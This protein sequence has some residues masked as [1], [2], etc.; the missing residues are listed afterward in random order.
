MRFTARPRMWGGVAPYGDAFHGPPPGR[1]ASRRRAMAFAPTLSLN[2]TQRTGLQRP[3]THIQYDMGREGGVHFALGLDGC[4]RH[5][6][7]G[8]RDD[9][10]ERKN[11]CV[12]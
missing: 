2:K 8:R 9:E 3:R 5:G 7:D 11:A 1:G 12:S 10:R 4:R 6:T